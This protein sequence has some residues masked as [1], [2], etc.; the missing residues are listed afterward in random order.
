M[1]PLF[2]PNAEIVFIPWG[3]G[4]IGEVRILGKVVWDYMIKSFP[5]LI[6]TLQKAKIDDYGYLIC[7]V[8]VQGTQ[9]QDFWAI[10]NR[11]HSFVIDQ[12]FLFH[13]NEQSLIDK[14]SVNWDHYEWQRQLGAK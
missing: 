14:M 9:V 8:E 12:I 10:R 2:T 5:N 7:E 13:F 1:N 6:H 11:G 4:G 3:E